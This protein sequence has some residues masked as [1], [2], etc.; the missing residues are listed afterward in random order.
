MKKLI[1]FF[2]VS[3]LSRRLALG[4]LVAVGLLWLV[5]RFC[6]LENSPPGFFLDEATAAVHAM[7]LAER[8]KDAYGVAWPLY[9]RGAIPEGGQHPLTLLA[10][11]VL[12]LKIFG[13]S[14]AAFR[15]VSAFWFVV[16]SLGLLL[17]T[18]DLA[19][20]IPAKSADEPKS[21]ARR[22]FPWM[23]L[24]SA[25]LSPWSFQFSRIAW[26][27]PLGPAFMV[28]A[29]VGVVRSHRGGRLALVWAA[30]A[31]FC[32]AASMTSYAPFRLVMPLLLTTA[33]A[34]L[35]A[36][37][38]TRRARLKFVGGMFVAAIAA[39]AFF[40]PTLRMLLSGKITQRMNTVAIW[41]PTWMS[42][43]MGQMRRTT[44]LV[45]TFL[46]NLLAHLQP[47]FLFVRGDAN[48]RHSPQI[49]GQLS[50]VD[51]LALALVCGTAARILWGLIRGR[52]PLPKVTEG[53][54]TD[55]SRWLM[56]I[57]LCA[58]LGGFFA[59]VPS[60]LTWE[61]VP[62]ALRSIGAWP[63]VALFSGAV[64]AMAWSRLPGVP[65][66]L[67]I[68]ALVY[69]LLFLPAYFHAYDVDRAE[70]FWFMRDLPDA[71]ASERLK[72]QPK[73]LG[74]IIS[75]NLGYSYNYDEVSRYYL[76]SQANMKC[77]QAVVGLQSYWNKAYRQ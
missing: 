44:F 11:D 51:I 35:L 46:D 67:A 6:G 42:E 14:R 12:W 20:L 8:G 19:G 30:F 21:S 60:A 70:R 65:A 76:M 1:D 33:V 41:N 9:S 28:L 53:F 75:A 22:A 2:L 27:C 39:V 4:T 16:T 63:F 23:V 15:A 17:L 18:R 43:H 77:S 3:P 29:L 58:I 13:T 66:L 71:I 62:T 10:F 40:S 74:Q 59:V 37:T 54:L 57:A 55:S 56:A 72:Q 34:I 68:V 7:C 64:L 26:E 52:S 25:L 61:G 73:S 24:L 48:L 5:I 47:S 45:T 36:I 69:T 50:P 49:S 38:G 31:G 32:A